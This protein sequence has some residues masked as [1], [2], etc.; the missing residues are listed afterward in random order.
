MD[1]NPISCC[2]VIYDL[3]YYVNVLHTPPIHTSDSE[4]ENL[5][6]LLN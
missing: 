2:V 4:T 3:H 5:L 6:K 1:Q